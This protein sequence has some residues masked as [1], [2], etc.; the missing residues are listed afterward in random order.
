ML[1]FD[2]KKGR[3]GRTHI[4]LTFLKNISLSKG[5]LGLLGSEKMDNDE[6]QRERCGVEARA[7]RE[8]GVV[9]FVEARSPREKGLVLAEAASVNTDFCLLNTKSQSWVTF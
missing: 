7:P 3:L 2:I 1:T 4:I 5:T 9:C 6:Y 8:K